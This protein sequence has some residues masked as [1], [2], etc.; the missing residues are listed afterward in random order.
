MTGRPDNPTFL[1]TTADNPAHDKC[2][3]DENPLCER[4]FKVS[5]CHERFC[6]MPGIK[7]VDCGSE[8]LSHTI[9]PKVQFECLGKTDKVS[10]HSEVRNGTY[11]KR[12]P[13]L[14][15]PTGGNDVR[16][17]EVDSQQLHPVFDV[18]VSV[19]ILHHLQVYPHDEYRDCIQGLQHVQDRVGKS[20]G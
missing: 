18:V 3:S 10:N 14:E 19:D 6:P 12:N 4:V 8:I 7:S 16:E 11:A 17:V 1:R 15:G 9:Q 13:I 2:D 20:L 5:V